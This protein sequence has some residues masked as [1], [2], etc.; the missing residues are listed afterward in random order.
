M[1]HSSKEAP[2]QDLRLIYVLVVI[3]EALVV[4]SLFWLGRVFS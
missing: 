2:E 1:S 3:V 4:L